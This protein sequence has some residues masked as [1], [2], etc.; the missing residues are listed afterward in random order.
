M[1]MMISIIMMML[2]D[3]YENND[4]IMVNMTTMDMMIYDDKK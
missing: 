3:G 1:M 2:M 4:M